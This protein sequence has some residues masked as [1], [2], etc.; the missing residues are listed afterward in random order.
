MVRGTFATASTIMG[1]QTTARTAL[2]HWSLI[3]RLVAVLLAAHLFIV[4]QL[5]NDLG[6]FAA[7]EECGNTMPP[8]LEEEVLKHACEVRFGTLPEDLSTTVQVFLHWYQDS[9]LDHPALEV[10]HQP[11][12]VC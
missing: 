5:T 4:P 2:R 12:K 9:M 1:S 11:P 8:I 7:L 10:P 3:Q 6:V